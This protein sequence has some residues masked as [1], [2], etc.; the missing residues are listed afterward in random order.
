M[1]E[2]KHCHLKCKIN[3]QNEEFK[4]EG[5]NQNAQKIQKSKTKGPEPIKS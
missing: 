2:V 1:T 3:E 4:E 5:K